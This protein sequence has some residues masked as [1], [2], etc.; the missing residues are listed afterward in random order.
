MPFYSI[1]SGTVLRHVCFPLH[2]LE[3]PIARMADARA[4]LHRIRF[5]HPLLRHDDPAHAR[6]FWAR[7]ADHEKTSIVLI[8]RVAGGDEGVVDVDPALLLLI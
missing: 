5:A 6:H 1:L 3:Y 4:H 8:D 7:S 2:Q